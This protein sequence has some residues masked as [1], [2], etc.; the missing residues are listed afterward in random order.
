M[1]LEQL[2]PTVVDYNGDGNN[3]LLVSERSG[4]VA[5][6]LGKGG[7]FK[8]G[9]PIPFHSFITIDG[10]PPTLPANT[11]T[12]EPGASLDPMDAIKATNLLSAGGG[13]TIATAD[14]NGDGIVNG[15]DIAP[16]LGAWGVVQ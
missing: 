1:G 4:K 11:P 12:P 16:L 5:V 7:P 2:S 8:P 10:A 14:F 3:D 6:Y 9:E 13:C 15:A